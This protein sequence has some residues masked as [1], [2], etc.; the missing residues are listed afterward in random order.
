MKM[1][2]FVMICYIVLLQ[3]ILWEYFLLTGLYIVGIGLCS[4]CWKLWGVSSSPALP[5]EAPSDP[6]GD[7]NPLIPGVILLL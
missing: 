4:V 5:W 7:T 6:G 3:F 2:I 1:T